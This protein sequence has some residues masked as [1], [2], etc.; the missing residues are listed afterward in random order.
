MPDNPALRAVMGQI[1]GPRPQ[2]SPQPTTTAPGGQQI[3]GGIAGVAS[4]LEADS[5]KIY[6]ERQ[7]YNEWEF[8]YDFSKDRK[9]G[10]AIGQTPGQPRAN[11]P[12]AQPVTNPPSGPQPFGPS[13][14][15]APFQPQPVKP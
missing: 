8:I 10:G 6:N 2:G 9:R 11:Q 15:N 3:G 5:I 1:Y 7:K 4:K 12:G 14:P 13:G